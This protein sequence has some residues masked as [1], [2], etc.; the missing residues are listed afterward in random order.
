[1]ALRLRLLQRALEQRLADAALAE[2]R[3]DGERAE[4]KR[5]RLPD[6][7]RRQPHRADHQRADPRG[8]REIEPMGDLFP[9]AVGGARIAPGTERALVQAVD[10]LRVLRGFGQDGQGKIAHRPRPHPPAMPEARARLA[11]D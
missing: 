9:D 1:M 6:A 2:R 4:Q 5:R 11:A 3:L 7:D 10:R 8:E